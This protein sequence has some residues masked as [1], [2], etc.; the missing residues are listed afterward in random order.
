MAKISWISLGSIVILAAGLVA[1]HPALL[2][3]RRIECFTQYGACQ[4]DFVDRVQFLVGRPIYLPLP[5]QQ[6]AQTFAGLAAVAEVTAYRRLPS[7]LV[8]GV[9]LR[10]PIAVVLGASQQQVVVDDRGVVFDVTDR[11]A[12]PLMWVDGQVAVGTNLSGPQLAA[13]KL[14]N[15]VGSII[16]T[17]V[18]GKLQNQLLFVTTGS[19]VE[20]ILDVNHVPADWAT[21]L[22]AIWA[23]SKIDGKPQVRK[24]DLRFSQPAVSF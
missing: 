22:Q 12:L 19:G 24:I 7:T 13:A 9:T 1:F 3:V 17:P 20:I 15:Q 11:S 6:I 8:L 5:R 10:R 2:R 23:R 4:S 21:S 14:L 18:A 16:R